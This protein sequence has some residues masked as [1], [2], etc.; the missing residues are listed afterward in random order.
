MKAPQIQ[1]P[2]LKF[3]MTPLIDITFLLIVF[4]VMSNRLIHEEVAIDL[5]LPRET[6]GVALEQD[7]NAK[8]IIN[9]T[10]DATYYLGAKQMGIDELKERL[11]REKARA[12][13]PTSVRIR[14]DRATPYGA[15]EPALVVCAQVGFY[16][17]SFSV[18]QE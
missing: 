10:S 8:S 7:E 18:A 14:A 2:S 5:E 4:F 6:S 17:V 16:D 12:T 1:R 11:Q 9:I 15:V 3:N 13:R